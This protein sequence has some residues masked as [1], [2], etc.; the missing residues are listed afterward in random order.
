MEEFDYLNSNVSKAFNESL[1]DRTSLVLER[2]IR[3]RARLLHNL[4]YPKDEAVLRIRRNL[5]W[6]FDDTWTRKEPKVMA[7]VETIVS[8]L[9]K[10][11]TNKR[12]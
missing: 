11:L 7:M 1:E 9:Y 12:D 5:A 8:E 2:E 10:H 4:R 6:E 3:E